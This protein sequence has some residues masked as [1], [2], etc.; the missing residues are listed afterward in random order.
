MKF[1]LLA[2]VLSTASAINIVEHHSPFARELCYPMSSAT[3]QQSLVQTDA[4]K[5][6]WKWNRPGFYTDDKTVEDLSGE[7]ALEM[8]Y[9]KEL[10]HPV[11]VEVYHPDCPHC[12]ALTPKFS[13]AA[14]Y[15]ADRKYRVEAFGVNISQLAQDSF[16]KVLNPTG[17]A[18]G[19]VPDVRL[20]TETGKYISYQGEDLDPK[21]LV[22][23]I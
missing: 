18:A 20:Y 22:A 6:G 12:K 19:G 3:T 10:Q 21:A 11:L 14:Q 4:A 23:F 15:L 17:P 7:K 13:A 2:T 5:G 16:E 8:L 1:A 9:K